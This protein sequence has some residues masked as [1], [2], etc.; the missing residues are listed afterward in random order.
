M[1]AYGPCPNNIAFVAVLSACAHSGLIDDAHG[2]FSSMKEVYGLVP[3]VE[4]HVCMVDMFGSAGFLD[5]AYQF[6]KKN[7][8]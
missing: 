6:I 2:V 7:S 3:G 8:S 4:H 5:G 1:R